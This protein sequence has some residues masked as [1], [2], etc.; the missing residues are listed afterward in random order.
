MLEYVTQGFFHDAF[1]RQREGFSKNGPIN[2][3]N[4]FVCVYVCLSL[5]F[6][7]YLYFCVRVV[8]HAYIYTYIWVCSH[9]GLF[10]F[11]HISTVFCWEGVW[12]RKRVCEGESWGGWGRERIV[13]IKTISFSL[14]PT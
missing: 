3:F 13:T 1:I 10:V 2:V 5:C 8:A 9:M 4:F 12:Q 14:D 11:T 6:F 7:E